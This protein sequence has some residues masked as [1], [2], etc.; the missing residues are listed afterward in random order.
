MNSGPP[1]VEPE[2]TSSVP[3]AWPQLFEDWR[4][5][6]A[7]CRRKPS[8]R[9]VHALRVATLRLQARLELGMAAHGGGDREKK[10]AK[11][12]M[13]QAEKLREAL[14]QVRETDV[15]LASLSGLRK[16]L[17]P[18]EAGYQPRPNRL[19]LS[20]I[21][22]LERALKKQRKKA[23]GRTADE[24]GARSGRFRQASEAAE[25]DLAA[26]LPFPADADAATV[27]TM[28]EEVALDFPELDAGCLHDFRKRIKT[29][30][31]QAEEI[32]HAHPE[33][34]EIAATLK[35]IQDATGAWHD[36]EELARIARSKFRHSSSE[37]K[38]LLGTLTEESFAEALALCTARLAEFG[39]G[40]VHN[41]QA[42]DTLVQKAG[43][44]RAEI[45]RD[46]DQSLL[47]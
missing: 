38:E 28:L 12:W 34:K 2:R 42:L 13:R 46:V 40:T 45:P 9:R 39:A 30:R 18:S 7:G 8:R 25:A 35:E 27:Q 33:V 4:R 17:A 37:L 11:R 21:D 19:A 31:Y 47:A 26:R 3:S 15:H 22:A 24:I 16:T 10:A 41:Q 6:I 36:W 44:R 20:Q 43:V 23:A 5:L 29:V 32:A 14:S 1:A